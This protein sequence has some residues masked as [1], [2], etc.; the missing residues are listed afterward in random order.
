MDRGYFLR[1]HDRGVVEICEGVQLVASYIK[2][3]SNNSG[4]RAR[5]MRGGSAQ[6]PFFK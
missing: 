3:N 5:V 1:R 4:A 6:K 2:Y